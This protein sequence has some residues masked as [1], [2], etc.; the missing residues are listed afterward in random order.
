VFPGYLDQADLPAIYTASELLLYPS[1]LEAF[2]I[3]ITEAMRCGVPIV[4]SRINGLAE[5]AG[6][7]AILVDPGNPADI[8]DG[9]CRVLT[10][11]GLRELLSA[12]GLERARLFSW[13]SCA[14]RTLEILERVVSG[15]SRSALVGQRT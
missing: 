15:Q 1:N 11:P 13:E 10:E 7:A 5:I 14:R 3:P 9:I 12:R 6:D 2:P 4:T 8:A